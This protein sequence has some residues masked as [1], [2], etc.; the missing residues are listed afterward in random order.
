[1]QELNI[2]KGSLLAERFCVNAL[3][4]KGT[5][6]RVYSAVDSQT[7]KEV[8][9]KIETKKG[10]HSQLLNEVKILQKLKGVT[11]VPKYLYSSKDGD[12]GLLAMELLGES[13]RS[14]FARFNKTFSLKTVLLVSEEMLERIRTLHEYH[15]I[16]RDIKP[17]QFI[18]SYNDVENTIYL[19]DYGLAKK[20]VNKSGVHAAYAENRSFVG[21]Y[22][23]A[24]VNCHVGIQQGRRDDLESMCYSIAFLLNGDL[25]WVSRNKKK[26]SQTKIRKIKARTSPAKL[27]KGFPPEFCEL[28]KYVRGLNFDTEPDYNYMKGLLSSIK[29]KINMAEAIFDWNLPLREM[30][31]TETLMIKTRTIEK[32]SKSKEGD[33]RFRTLSSLFH[34]EL[35]SE[36]SRTVEKLNLPKLLNREIL[37]KHSCK[38]LSESKTLPMSFLFAKKAQKS[39]CKENLVRM[40][41]TSA[42]IEKSECLQKSNCVVF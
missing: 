27:M 26:Y 11:G 41:S 6:G 2:Q 3:V 19:V 1:M 22:H 33:T 34:E 29:L 36:S 18:T 4:G 30:T 31:K 25:P 24:S 15:Y 32:E 10:K 21:T 7:N 37:P 40:R 20:Y 14:K 38:G 12:Y 13:I 35:S 39:Y 8:A 9:V 5:F 28:L 16:H 17:Q 23:Y 42:E